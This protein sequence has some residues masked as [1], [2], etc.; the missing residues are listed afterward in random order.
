[1]E[2]NGLRQAQERMKHKMNFKDSLNIQN[3]CM[4][5]Q[6]IYHEENA[7]EL[8]FMMNAMCSHIAIL[9]LNNRCVDGEMHKEF[10]AHFMLII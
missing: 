3:Q 10:H 8:W 9:F 4:C 6:F 5:I 2:R 1:M 7:N